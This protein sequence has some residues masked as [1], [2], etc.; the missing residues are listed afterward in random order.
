M[1]SPGTLRKMPVQFTQKEHGIGSNSLERHR[2]FL[3]FTPTLNRAIA[4]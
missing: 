1:F 3:E 4:V 2:L